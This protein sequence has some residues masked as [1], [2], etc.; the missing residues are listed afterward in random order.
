MKEHCLISSTFPIFIFKILLHFRPTPYSIFLPMSRMLLSMLFFLMAAVHTS[1]AQVQTSI[2]TS[3][4][5]SSNDTTPFWFQSNR[6]GMYAP[7]GSQFMTRFQYYSNQNEVGIFD[8]QFGADMIARPGNNATLNF[9]QGYLNIHAYGVE[10]IAGRFHNTSP[11]QDDQLSMG[12]LGIST[13]ASPIPQI[14]LG[15]TDWTPIPFTK[16]FLKIKGHISHGWL[17]SRRYTEDL[18][19]HEKV[20]HL[21]VGGNLPINVYAGLAHYVKWGGNHPEYGDIPTRWSDFKNVFLAYPGDEQT[22]GPMQTYVLGDHLGAWDFG[23]FLDIG[24]TNISLY[25][26]HP[27]ES[28]DNLKLKSLQD[29]LT[30]I[31]IDL[32][33][34]SSLPVRRFLY[35]YLYTKYQ[36]GPR[37]E[38]FGGDLTRDRYRGNEN[39]YNHGIYRS[40][41]V[42]NYRTIGNPLFIPS[43]KNMGVLNNR[44]VAH[45]I[46]LISN[47]D[48]AELT[49]K[50]TF[51]RNYGKYCDNRVPDLGEG[52][53]F[54]VEC[55]EDNWNDNATEFIH[56]VSGH[57]VDQ[58]SFLAGMSIPIRF[59]ENQNIRFILEL[60][61]DNGSL[62]GDQF[63]AL[64][65]LRWLPR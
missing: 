13:N 3:G 60:A 11:L 42:Y 54:G 65:G 19:L 22:P 63:G 40:G 7:D 37:R 62:A 23:F 21:R 12:S 44:I 45:H 20:G 41:W 15:L 48:R 8:I 58:W 43:E 55:A 33:E 31:L 9:N 10:L 16:E 25:R 56:T 61:F 35:E 29:A 52:E 28:R 30:G 59:I 14:R 24:K 2:E 49:M 4:I 38:N 26:Q 17:G 57:S 18:L 47:I 5:I 6:H 32:P 39:Y 34:T 46:G 64:I 36:D 53:L 51:S 27:L 1:T 50:A